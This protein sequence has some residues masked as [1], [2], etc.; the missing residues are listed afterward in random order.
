M[1]C[2]CRHGIRVLVS[3]A[4]SGSIIFKVKA[5]ASL[6]PINRSSMHSLQRLRSLKP[7]ASPRQGAMS[8]IVAWSDLIC[9]SNPVRGVTLVCAR[10]YNNKAHIARRGE[11]FTFFQMPKICNYFIGAGLLYWTDIPLHWSDFSVSRA[12]GQH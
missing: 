10:N 6:L 8:D 9:N 3:Q 12:T 4:V 7:N 2:R 5:S 1:A 11:N